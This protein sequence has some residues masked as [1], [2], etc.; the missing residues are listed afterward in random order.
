MR[1]NGAEI[2]DAIYPSLYQINTRVWLTALSCTLGRP[3]TLDDI[4]DAALDQVAE[5]GFDWVWLLGVW[6]TGEAGP[7]LAVGTPARPAWDGAGGRLCRWSISALPT[8]SAMCVLPLG[9][10][11]PE[12]PVDH[13]VH[14]TVRYERQGDAV[15]GTGLSLDLP[16]RD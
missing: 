9:F 5:M 15:T 12:H 13:L 7:D 4:P 6:Q 16:P 11:R 10:L 3:A 1:S 2:P 8:P 14:P